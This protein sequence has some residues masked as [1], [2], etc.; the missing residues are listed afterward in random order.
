MCQAYKYSI[1]F[2]GLI[3]IE[4]I[5]KDIKGYEGIYQVSTFGRMKSLDRYVTRK[6]GAVQFYP[7]KFLKIC[8]NKRVDVYEVHLR[9]NNKRKCFK[10]HRLVA[11][12]FIENDDPINKTTV[13]HKDGKRE[14]NRVDNLEWATYSENEQHAYD[15][16]N[17][18]INR[19]K[20]LKRQCTSINKYTN[21]HTIYESIEVAS[22]GTNISVT[23][24]R[25]IANNE[26]VN[27]DY[28]FII[29]GI[30]D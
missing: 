20:Y 17:R 22:R 8:Y 11:E 30:N 3:Y 9:K 4:E 25:R 2:K 16:L 26:C 5:W 6:N 1:Y 15:K 12:A 10:V 19:A 18:P 27:K 23:Q 14:N 29:E 21:I 13:N 24:I 28:Y 7:G